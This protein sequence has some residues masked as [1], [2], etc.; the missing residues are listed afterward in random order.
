M[1][2]TFQLTNLAVAIRCFGIL[3]SGLQKIILSLK[4]HFYSMIQQLKFI[5]FKEVLKM[6]TILISVHS[7]L[8]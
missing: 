1:N 3:L 2:Q 4:N 5:V 6:N 8:K 7:D